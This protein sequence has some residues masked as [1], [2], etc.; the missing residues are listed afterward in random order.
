MSSSRAA[1]HHGDLAHAL[2]AAA[3]QLLADKPAT[4]ISLREVARAADVS[5]NA[6]YHHFSDR[7][8]LLKT[9]AER[10][11][12]EL[13]DD[14]RATLAAA[15]DATAALITGGQAYIRFAVERPHAFDVIYDPTVCIPGAPT[16]TMAPLI[17]ELET[18]LGG[19]VVNAGLHESA[20]T[21]CWG[22]VHGLGTLAAAGHF[23]LDVATTSFES[24]VRAMLAR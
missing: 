20:L 16:E 15:P 9:L 12:A 23:P 11:M 2:E 22:L 18:L 24:A 10:S 17:D 8:G 21:A 6:P 19:A 4:E 7:R 3:M 5:H 13:V 1:Y 14:V